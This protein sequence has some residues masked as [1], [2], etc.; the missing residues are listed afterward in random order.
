[1][2]HDQ[3]LPPLQAC[4]FMCMTNETKVF[5]RLIDTMH[6]VLKEAP[7]RISSTGI[8]IKMTD[9]QKYSFTSITLEAAGFNQ[10][11]LDFPLGMFDVGVIMDTMR[12][13]L[14]GM[15]A[16]DSLSMF[17]TKERPDQLG[18]CTY[19][20]ERRTR[21]MHVMSTLKCAYQ[22]FVMPEMQC[23]WRVRMDSSVFFEIIHQ[24]ASNRGT[25]V[26]LGLSNNCLCISSRGEFSQTTLSV[27]IKQGEVC[28][29]HELKP[30]SETEAVDTDPDPNLDP[31][32]DP[33]P[34]APPLSTND[35]KAKQ[36][37][38][39]KQAKQQDTNE[40]SGSVQT[41]PRPPK[42]RRLAR[43]LATGRGI[44]VLQTEGAA[45]SG[46]EYVQTP[47]TFYPLRIIEKFCKAH[48]LSPLCD[49][50]VINQGV[51]ILR[52]HVG[53]LGTIAYMITP[54]FEVDAPLRDNLAPSLD[55]GQPADLDRDES[56]SGDGDPSLADG[57]EDYAVLEEEE[58]EG[59]PY[60]GDE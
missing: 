38:Q 55:F 40:K 49:I 59:C 50:F 47:I 44:M 51:I 22:E 1:M 54:H 58:V 13:M 14:K 6:Q 37:M 39:A 15:S 17:I 23:D 33:D 20:S 9:P 25:T 24:L 48:V 32:P 10:Y 42:K 26:G 2:S 12:N 36:A 57:D 52:Y 41:R 43:N 56:Q 46:I 30:A 19:H 53:K 31:D 5:S 18:I 7:M 35:E 8:T 45:T 21:H 3:D 11:Y 29:R 60:D 28:A 16:H 34:S 27:E 4:H